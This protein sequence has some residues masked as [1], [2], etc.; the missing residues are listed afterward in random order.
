LRPDD[1]GELPA[2]GEKIKTMD[3]RKKILKTFCTTLEAAKILGVA[4]RTV[5]LWAESGL[6][7][8]WKTS[9]GHRRITRQSI[10]R[11]LLNPSGVA[12]PSGA[13]SSASEGVVAV[14]STPRPFR[15]LVVEDDANLRQL[16]ELKLMRWPMQPAVTTAGDGYEALILMGN[17]K[18]DLLI[19]D[20]NLPGMD[21]FRMIETIRSVPELGDMVIVVVTGIDAA[22]VKKRGVLAPDIQVLPK[23]VPFNVL[24][25][26]AEQVV[27]KPSAKKNAN[28]PD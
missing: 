13:N 7:E 21:G 6:L 8:A 14:A 11:L 22:E 16:Y 28:W 1:H 25:Q 18:P 19:V 27:L 2:S 24:M 26:I 9:G 4:Q 15:I 5:Q 10:E 20:L 12:P 23:P 3:S 17:T